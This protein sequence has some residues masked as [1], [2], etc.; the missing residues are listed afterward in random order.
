MLAQHDLSAEDYLDTLDIDAFGPGI[1][2]K[3]QALRQHVSDLDFDA[4]KILLDD[5]TLSRETTS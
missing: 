1:R 4:A 3:W 2:E 5:I